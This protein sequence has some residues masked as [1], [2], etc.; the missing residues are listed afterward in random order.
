MILQCGK[1]LQEPLLRHRLFKM[2]ISGKK[3]NLSL[4]TFNSL[5]ERGKIRSNI[6]FNKTIE[7]L[8]YDGNVFYKNLLPAYRL[9]AEIL[10][11]AL[12]LQSE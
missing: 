1:L 3:K 2:Q 6:D 4:K 8:E 7:K 9:E 12:I 10:D 11:L 5:V